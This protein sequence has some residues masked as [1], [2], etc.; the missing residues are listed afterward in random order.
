M[1]FSQIPHLSLLI[2]SWSLLFWGLLQHW[3]KLKMQ[4]PKDGPFVFFP[5]QKN[6][7]VEKLLKWKA[8]LE[9]QR[10]KASRRRKLMTPLIFPFS[11]TGLNPSEKILGTCF[12]E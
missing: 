2:P 9:S 6:S 1:D 8:A 7:A 3:N 11:K 10:R 4:H 12:L 5:K